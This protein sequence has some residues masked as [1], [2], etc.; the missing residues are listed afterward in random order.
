VVV[1]SRASLVA[2]AA[3]EMDTSHE[4]NTKAATAK[5]AAVFIGID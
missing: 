5:L 3:M 1:W 4:M 2:P